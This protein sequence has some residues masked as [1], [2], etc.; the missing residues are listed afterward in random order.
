[1]RRFEWLLIGL[2]LALMAMGV[3]IS[4]RRGEGSAFPVSTYQITQQSM[5][6][7][8]ANAVTTTLSNINGIVEQIEVV[9]NNN[10]GNAT[11]T[12]AITSA[13]SGTLYS[14]AAI[15]ENAT[16][17]YSALSNKGTQDAN[18]NPFLCDGTLTFT[19]TPSGDPGTSGMTVD[20]ILYVR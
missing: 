12:V 1:M 4:D 19:I 16:T 18:F 11:A 5:P 6:D 2:L 15:P 13:N 14:Q 3:T 9:I 8:D 20:V 17:V 7:G 10:T